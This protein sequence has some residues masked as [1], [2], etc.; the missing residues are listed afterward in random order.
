[1]EELIR[2]LNQFAPLS[3]AVENHLR[4]IIHRYSFKKWDYLLRAGD[5]AG[6]ILFLEKGLVRSWSI[7]VKTKRSRKT[8]KLKKE[9]VEVSNWF[10]SEGTIV[11]S[12]QSFLRQK[13]A[14]DS[15]QAQEDCVCWGITHA[16]LEATYLAFPEF[17]RVGRLITGFY[18]CLSE[19]RQLS[20]RMQDPLDKYRYILDTT[21]DLLER[22]QQKYMS[23]YLGVS[24]RTF[25]NMRDKY[26]NGDWADKR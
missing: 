21:P 19:D 8:K 1:M 25:Q 23:S 4:T 18:Y 26:R 12:V 16:E 7:I 22:V 11:I 9:K 5:V 3:A 6:Q 24:L 10:M 13:P 2:L 17:E 14:H 20:Q 15:I